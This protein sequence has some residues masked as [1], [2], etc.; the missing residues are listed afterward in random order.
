MDL[1]TAN[2][3]L[4]AGGWGYWQVPDWLEGTFSEVKPKL[5][6]K[7]SYGANILGRSSEGGRRFGAE[8]VLGSQSST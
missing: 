3:F 8:K 5:C 1:P 4:G 2:P 7:S 6:P